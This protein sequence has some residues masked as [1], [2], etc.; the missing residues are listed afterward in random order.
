MPQSDNFNEDFVSQQPTPTRVRPELTDRPEPDPQ[1]PG[2]HEPVS[3]VRG[4]KHGWVRGHGHRRFVDWPTGC[5]WRPA[6]APGGVAEW[7]GR[8]LQ[9]PVQR[10]NSAPRL[11]RVRRDVGPLEWRPRAT[12]AVSSGGERFPDTE[13]AGGSNPPPPTRKSS[14]AQPQALEPDPQRQLGAEKG[15]Y[16]AV[17]DRE[18]RLQTAEAQPCRDGIVMVPNRGHPL[19]IH[20]G[21]REVSQALDFVKRA[22]ER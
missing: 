21:R 2:L 11:S 15:P 18:R 6:H 22:P 5:F 8:G 3:R 1:R 17:G 16:S 10:F 14:Q 12:R 9:N 7:L 20:L 13:E 19:T 4:H